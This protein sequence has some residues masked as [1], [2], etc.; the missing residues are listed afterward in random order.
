MN[1]S[2]CWS[3]RVAIQQVV[4]A[5]LH[6]KIII[7]IG[8]L[9]DTCKGRLYIGEE[10][11]HILQYRKPLDFKLD[12]MECSFDGLYR[13]TGFSYR[14][15]SWLWYGGGS[16]CGRA[17]Q[18]PFTIGRRGRG[19]AEFCLDCRNHANHKVWLSSSS[20]E[21]EWYSCLLPLS[22]VK[23]SSSSLLFCS[24]YL[25][26]T[27]PLYPIRN[28]GSQHCPLIHDFHRLCIPIRITYHPHV[29]RL[30]NS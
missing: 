12:G 29:I 2:L 21:I 11:E 23:Y 20:G 25:T 22:V 4:E 18:S 8:L 15:R 26:F 27:P 16:I 10:I 19:S 7:R 6:D 24:R 14:E 9:L 17:D 13:S 1:G 5:V 28:T 30:S 3:W